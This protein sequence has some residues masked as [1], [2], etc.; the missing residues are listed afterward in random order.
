ML[1]SLKMRSKAAVNLIDATAV[2]ID[3]PS[4]HVDINA[5]TFETSLATI[6]LKE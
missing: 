5:A 6:L 1:T 3:R 4:L 2:P